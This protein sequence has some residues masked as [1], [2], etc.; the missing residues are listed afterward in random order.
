MKS[1]FAAAI[2]LAFVSASAFA[3]AQ[4]AP[5]PGPEV[6]RLGYYVGTWRGQGET[7]AGP[8]GPAGKLASKIA[9]G[10]FEG[11]FHLVCRG[12]ETGPTGTRAFLEIRGYDARAKAY[13]GYSISSLGDTESVSGGKFAGDKL[14]FLLSGGKGVRIRYTEAHVS[15]DLYTYSAEASIGGKPWATIAEGRIV[16]VK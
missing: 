7:K 15:R 10:W 9:C 8:F 2:I 11:R 14:V 3:Q 5:K 4:Q 13:T 1:A 12:E 16:R 6:A